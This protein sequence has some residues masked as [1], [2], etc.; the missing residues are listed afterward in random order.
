MPMIVTWLDPRQGETM[1]VGDGE[2]VVTEGG[3]ARCFSVLRPV[4]QRVVGYT[5]GPY[6]RSGAC[7]APET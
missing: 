4:T 1:Q 6:R 5:G 2:I 7:L 3:Q